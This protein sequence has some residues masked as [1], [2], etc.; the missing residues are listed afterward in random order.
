[1]SRR[2]ARLAAQIQEE[3]CD[4]LARKIRDPRVGFVT[5][6]GVKVT[7]DLS[8]ADVYVSVMGTGEE[9]KRTLDS[10]EGARSYIR[11]ELGSRLRVKH[12]PEI[13]FHHDTSAERGARIDS[14]LRDLK[15]CAQECNEEHGDDQGATDGGSLQED[16]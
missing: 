9:V 4:V 14:L 5:L 8:Y 12:V 3:I 10:L 2:L 15:E 16:S 11:S 1:M 13:R 7:A 6:T